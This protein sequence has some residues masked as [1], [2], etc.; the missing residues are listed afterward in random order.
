MVAEIIGSVVLRH[1]KLEVP[2]KLWGKY[3]VSD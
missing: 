2:V 1:F 3:L